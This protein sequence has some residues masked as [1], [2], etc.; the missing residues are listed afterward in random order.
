[1]RLV[2]QFEGSRRESMLLFLVLRH[3]LPAS[4]VVGGCLRIVCLEVGVILY[5]I[6]FFY[7]IVCSIHEVRRERGGKADLDPSGWLLGNTIDGTQAEYVRIPHADSSLHPIPDG[8]DADVLVML[9]DIFPTGFEIGVLN[10]NVQP[11]SSVAIVGAGP[12]GLAT[13]ITAQLYSP[14]TIIVVDKDENRLSVAKSFGAHYAFDPSDGKAE[15]TVKALTDGKGCNAVVE[16]VGVPET[17][18]LC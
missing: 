1:M 2:L 7:Y 6:A 10:G 17:F 11:G 12:I 18:E 8:A 3:A 13:L 4:I 14:S 9:S 5:S 15:E 16:A